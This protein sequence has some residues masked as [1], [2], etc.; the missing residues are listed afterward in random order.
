MKFKHKGLQALFERDD[1]RR[2]RGDLVQRV[3]HILSPAGCGAVADQHRHAPWISP[4]S[5]QGRPARA[6]EHEGIWEHWRIVFRF[7][8]GEAVDVDLLD[9]H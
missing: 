4:P 1:S 2:V 9:Y 6:V 5:T 7:V 3:K 8:D